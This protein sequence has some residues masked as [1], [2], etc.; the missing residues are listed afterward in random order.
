MS[1]AQPQSDTFCWS[2]HEHWMLECQ[3]LAHQLWGTSFVEAFLRSPPDRLLA[4]NWN[5][6]SPY[7]SEERRYDRWLDVDE[8][9][10]SAFCKRWSYIVAFHGCSVENLDS[11]R[12]NGLLPLSLG[13]MNEKARRIALS[14]CPRLN[15]RDIDKAIEEVSKEYDASDEHTCVAIDA[16]H[17]VKYCSHYLLYGSEYLQALFRHIRPSD[18]QGPSCDMRRLL[19]NRGRATVLKCRVPVKSIGKRALGELSRIAMVAAFRRLKDETYVPESRRLGFAI[20]GRLS[21]EFILEC[22][23]PCDLQDRLKPFIESQRCRWKCD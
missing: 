11:Y 5:W 2:M 9:V 14:S 21:P 1:T 12:Q 22:A 15:E 10:T 16:T 4:M 19:R 13:A 18:A 17:L 6:I 23:H 3:R 8:A 7:V 20:R